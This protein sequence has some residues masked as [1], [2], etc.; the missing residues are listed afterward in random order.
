M[1]ILSLSKK[2][3]DKVGK[4]SLLLL[5][6]WVIFLSVIY[7][8]LAVVRHNHYESGAFDLGIFDQAVWQYANFL[9]P[10]NTIKERFILGDHLTL[11]LPLLAPL[12]YLFDDVRML[13]VFQAA[14]I[15]FSS[16]AVYLLALK[17]KFS[18]YVALLAAVI[19]SLFFGIQTAVSFDFHPIVLGVGLLMWVAYLY[20]AGK[21]KL[22]WVVLLL[23][24]LTQENVG[25]GL[26]GLGFIYLFQKGRRK[27]ALMFI[28]GGI[29]FSLLATRVIALLSP[30][31]YQY[32]PQISLNPLQLLLDYFNAPEK[33]Q[34][35]IYSLTG[36]GFLPLLSPG[37]M[38]A[39]LLDLAQYFLSGFSRMWT[40]YQHHRAI[41]SVFLL[42]GLL[43]GLV[44]LQK[45]KVKPELVISLILIGCLFFQYFFHYPIN[46]LSK[47]AFWETP[48]W[49]RDNNQ[50]LGKIPKDASVVAQQS[51]VPHVAHR[52]EIYL[53]WPRKKDSLPD[54]LC[55][56]T[57]CWWLDF[58]GKP[59]YL[60]VD[61]HDGQWITQLLET[62]EH[63][64]IAITA[65]E[66]AGKIKEVTRVNNAYLYEV[67][68]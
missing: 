3:S 21:Q 8:L 65:M 28:L 2:F 66:K 31:G 56:N 30:V 55:Q 33:K 23:A 32:D 25:I 35:W 15:S 52:K 64:K 24:L 36:F 5:I 47:K 7:S 16:I 38:L 37:A 41:L 58:V 20:E 57:E 43:D 19:F 13:L 12:F 4:H 53:F 44:F 17:R 14:F 48:Q 49:V 10:Y 60:V 59:Q 9:S 22:F 54:N 50:L 1:S 51:V 27:N 34:T 68:Y 40:P 61:L 46:K 11:T 67:A 18:P 26:A 42:L 39:V 6:L 45:R 29:G 62:N 63:V